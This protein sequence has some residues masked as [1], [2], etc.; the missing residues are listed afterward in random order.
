MASIQKPY[1]FIIL[2][3]PRTKKNSGRIFHN[4]A[5]GAPI[6]LPSAA[7][8]EWESKAVWQLMDQWRRKAL[9]GDVG[10][11]A[12]FYRERDAGDLVNYMQALADALQVAKVIED[13]RQIVCWDGT[14]LNKD[15]AR[16][17]VEVQLTHYGSLK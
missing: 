16:P 2:G 5:S 3:A 6:L 9:A 7:S 12:M 1:Q 14:R 8:K 4:R 10:V 11:N 15:A 17:R 13:D